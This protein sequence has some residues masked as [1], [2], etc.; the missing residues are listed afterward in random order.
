MSPVG[1]ANC[2]CNGVPSDK[3]C[4]Y[5]VTRPGSRHLVG[6]DAGIRRLV[7]LHR[8]PFGGGGAVFPAGRCPPPAPVGVARATGQTAAMSSLARSQLSV[9]IDTVGDLAGR[10][11]VLAEQLHEGSTSEAANA[12]VEAERSLLMAAR[13]LVRAQRTLDA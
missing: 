4:V 7:S 3:R 12:L 2:G 13:A 11:A 6:R 8:R 1:A 10:T 5:S 9:L